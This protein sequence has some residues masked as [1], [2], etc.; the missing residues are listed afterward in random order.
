MITVDYH[1][2][3]EHQ[4][5]FYS[6][7]NELGESRRRDGGYFWSHFQDTADPC[8]I[9]EVLLVESWAEHLRQHERVTRS[10]QQLQ[11]DLSAFLQDGTEPRARHFVHEK[12]GGYVEKQA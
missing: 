11:N 6:T 3:P 12:S 9:R 1:V 2:K 7:L 8:L 10:D 4:E 5:A